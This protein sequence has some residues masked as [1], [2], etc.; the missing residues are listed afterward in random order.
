MLDVREL[1]KKFGEEIKS[2]QFL[3]LKAKRDFLQI[4]AFSSSIALL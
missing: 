4:G 2:F 3:V 1:A